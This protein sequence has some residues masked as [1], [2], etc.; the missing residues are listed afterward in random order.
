MCVADWAELRERV[1]ADEL[2]LVVAD[3]VEGGQGAGVP[4]EDRVGPEATGR[5][6]LERV[7]HALG[8]VGE[9]G[10]AAVQ[11]GIEVLKGAGAQGR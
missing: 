5:E 8:D 7:L 4:R 1:V 6:A 3:V 2:R 10:V 9:L 11:E